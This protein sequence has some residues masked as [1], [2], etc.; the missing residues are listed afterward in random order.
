MARYYLHL[1][2]LHGDVIEDEEGS[3]FPSLALAKRHAM[4]AMH[5]L[6]GD[7][8]KQGREPDFEAIVIADEHGTHLAGVPIVTALPSRLVGLLKHPEKV[9]PA[10]RFEEYRRNAHDCRRKAENTADLDD[11]VSWLELADAWLQMLPPTRLPK[12]DVADWPEASEEDS[13]ASH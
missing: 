1:R 10:D 5:D 3:E 9:V 2:N 7:A 13:K 11:K 12:G 8:I 6:V 4:L